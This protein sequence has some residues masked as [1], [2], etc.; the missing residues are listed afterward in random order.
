MYV[1]DPILGWTM[2]PNI[3]KKDWIEGRKI[4]FWTNSKGLRSPEHSYSTPND[5][6]RVLLLGDSF[7]QGDQV[8]Y[9]ELLSERLSS[10]LGPEWQVI[11]AGTDGWSTLQEYRWYMIEGRSYHPDW[12]VLFIHD[13]DFYQN[14][15]P[16]HIVFSP[17]KNGKSKLTKLKE[18]LGGHS[19]LYQLA[20]RKIKSSP[21]LMKLTL[22]LGLT[23]K[24][25]PIPDEFLIWDKSMTST[26]SKWINA[27]MF[28]ISELKKEVAQAN[29]KLIVVWVPSR[30]ACDDV[31]WIH[32]KSLYNL[33]NSYDPIFPGAVLQIITD[34]LR[35][36]FI[37]PR[38]VLASD[39]AP[40]YYAVDPHWTPRGH[41]LVAELV[42]D[43]IQKHSRADKKAH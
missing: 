24:G 27:T 18:W 38:G 23:R 15:H 22:G 34:K 29:S 14:A 41:N 37:N 30:A 2:K 31:S 43:T 9:D 3:Y 26:V 40:T 1:P 4:T 11:N 7:L 13:N 33:P 5:T 10:L 8:Q 21:M 35:I 28:I 16:E 20:R 36:R 25:A 42:R 32:T 12:V 6:K 17:Q 39:P 19:K